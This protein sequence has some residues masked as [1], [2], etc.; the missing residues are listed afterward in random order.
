MVGGISRTARYKTID[1]TLVGIVS[2][3]RLRPFKNSGKNL[4]RR[5]YETFFKTYTEKVWGIPSTDIRAEW[6]A[7]RI[8]GLSLTRAF[9]SASTVQRRDA[10]IKTLLHAF[11]YSRWD[12]V[13]CGKRHET[14]STHWMLECSCNTSR[15]ELRS[16]GGW[17][18]PLCATRT[19][20]G[21]ALRRTMTSQP[22]I[23]GR[24][25]FHPGY[26]VSIQGALVGFVSLFVIGYAW[27]D[28]RDHRTTF[29]AG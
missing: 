27:G 19:L 17:R 9:L 25:L 14:V 18:T 13:K 16:R 28:Y 5:L 11:K 15:R 26:S 22:P 10:S 29:C 21:F 20:A 8:Q 4:G 2:S 24:L 7:Q 3:R 12:P 1:S 6:T 23:F